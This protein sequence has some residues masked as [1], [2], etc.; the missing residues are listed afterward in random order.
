MR[1]SQRVRDF[2]QL[3]ADHFNLVTARKPVAE[4]APAEQAEAATAPSAGRPSLLASS[5]VSPR[6]GA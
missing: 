5:A 3:D 2:A 4:R 1:E 6:A